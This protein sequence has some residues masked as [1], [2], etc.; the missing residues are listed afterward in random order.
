M[1]IQKQHI[2]NIKELTANIKD[3]IGVPVNTM[4][5]ATAIESMGIR[6]KDTLTDFGQ[7][8]IIVLAE[9]IFNELRT[10]AEHR[11]AKNAK[12]KMVAELHQK[13]LE[14]TNHFQTNLILLLKSFVLGITNLFPVL[15][16]FMMIIFFGYSLWTSVDFNT[17]QST[18]VVLGVIVGMIISGGFV[19]VIGR[20]ASFYWSYNDFEMTKK[21]I[22]YILKKGTWAIL[23]GLSLLFILNMFLSFY[24]NKVLIIT[25]IYAFL[26]GLLI[27]YLAPLYPIKQR[28]FISVAVFIGTTISI[29]LAKKTNLMIYFTHWIGLIT[30]IGLSKLFQHLFF[31]RILHKTVKIAQNK[32]NTPVLLYHNYKYFFY[33]LFIYLFVFIDRILAWSSELDGLM[34]FV[35]YFKKDYELGMDIA[36]V[37]FLFMG[38]VLEYSVKVFTHFLDLQQRLTKYN[39]VKHFNGYF[40]MMYWRNVLIL[41]VSSTVLF[42]ITY[43]LITSP[44]GY[45]SRFH[46]KLLGLSYTVASFGCI[47]YLFLAWGMMNSL[48]L[49][50]LGRPT[51]PLKAIIIATVVNI[52]TGFVFSRFVG[53]EY[54]V[55]GMVM[56]SLVFMVL[57]LK[58]NVSFFKNLDYNYYSAY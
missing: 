24:P 57:T 47:G 10:A 22:N 50:T 9:L 58:E 53:Y 1:E 40:T 31:K 16:Q 45:E 5:V 19:Q 14:N 54:S 56:G 55:I 20:Q 52:I 4:V 46:I 8:S 32:I 39:E 11:G 42:I 43:F 41:L 17:L 12:E 29:V 7:A 25:F 21:T 37:S 48:Y 33:G 34:P 6:D 18:A 35:I 44:W 2:E 3:K 13:E 36:I 51:E 30:V 49:F 15:L 28:W 27:L 26:I 38:G 23:I